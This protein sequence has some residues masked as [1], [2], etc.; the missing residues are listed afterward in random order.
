MSTVVPII[1]DFPLMHYTERSHT[2]SR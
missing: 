2:D 1:H